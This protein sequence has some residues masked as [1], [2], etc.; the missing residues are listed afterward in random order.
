M[1]LNR[2]LAFAD[3][4]R[5]E[6]LR[7][8]LSLVFGVA[9]PLV[10]LFL[11]SAIRR[12]T[13]Q[14]IF[15]IAS[16]APGTIVFGQAFIAMFTGLLVA[17]D[18]GGA[19]LK[20]LFASPLDAADFI[21]GYSLPLLPLSTAQAA[22]CLLCALP[23]GLDL[24]ALSF[25][26]TLLTLLPSALLFISMGLLLGCLL[27]E[28]QVGGVGSILVQVVAFTSGMWFDPALVGGFF[29]TLSRALPFLSAL[30]A[31]QSALNGAFDGKALLMVCAWAIAASTAAIL[32]FRRRMKQGT[33]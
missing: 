33:H 27:R 1:K 22:L 13:G 19:Y 11:M 31:A 16:F 7:D 14:D 12:S 24:T 29:L 30:N 9:L 15:P 21:V 5:K 3:R 4:T 25:L 28:T 32:L 18:R 20:R 23:L 10:L 2:T 17:Q 8:P 26:L 6:L